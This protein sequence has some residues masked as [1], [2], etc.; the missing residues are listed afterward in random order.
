M[1]KQITNNLIVKDDHL[2]VFEE[3]NE[4]N[5]KDKVKDFISKSA[6][7]DLKEKLRD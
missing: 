5:K 6:K 1:I 3:E 2:I 4:N 7:K